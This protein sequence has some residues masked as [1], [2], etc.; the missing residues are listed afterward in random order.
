MTF[1]PTARDVSENGQ[2]G[3]LVVIIPKNEWI[4]PEKQQRKSNDDQTG[5]N[6]T[7]CVGARR[8]RLGHHPISTPNAQRPTLN[9][10]CQIA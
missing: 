7:Y 9:V 3:K 5:N 1:A 8:S 4:V 10:Q 2:D 6:R